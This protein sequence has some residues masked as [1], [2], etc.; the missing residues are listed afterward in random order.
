MSM[1]MTCRVN[2]VCQ[3]DI[4]T[5]AVMSKGLGPEDAVII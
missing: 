2:V 3:F 1:S 5:Q 4:V